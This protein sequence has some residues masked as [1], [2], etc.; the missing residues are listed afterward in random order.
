MCGPEAPLG[1][2]LAPC[3]TWSWLGT[4]FDLLELGPSATRRHIGLAREQLGQVDDARAADGR[5]EIADGAKW[6][7]DATGHLRWLHG[8]I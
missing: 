1:L 5:V 7:I 2:Y 3:S 8:L 4:I 6:G